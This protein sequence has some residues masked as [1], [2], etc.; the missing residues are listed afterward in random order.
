MNVIYAKSI[1]YAYSNI[2]VIA[3]Q[4]D[5]LVVKKALSSMTDFSPALSQCEKIVDLTCQK[6]LLLKLKTVVYNVLLKFSD[7]ELDFFD[8]KYF[9]K[10]PK[11]YYI[12]FDYQSRNYFRRQIRLAAKFSLRLE[13]SGIT[14]SVFE[15]E[16]LKIEF[17]RELVKRVTEYELLSCKNKGKKNVKKE[18]S[19][20]NGE[21]IR[22]KIA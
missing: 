4:I 6:E 16:Y 17:F 13:K 1:L 3:E 10:K 15:N 8:Y 20:N 22:Q 2:D 9:K 21:I 5:E 11:E 14:D 12:G 7:T 19:E 18:K